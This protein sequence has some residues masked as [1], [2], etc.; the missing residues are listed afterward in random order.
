[1]PIYVYKCVSYQVDVLVDADSEEE[2]KM[3]LAGIVR[4]PDD[5]YLDEIKD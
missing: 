3:I 5:F 1:M 4:K 2:A